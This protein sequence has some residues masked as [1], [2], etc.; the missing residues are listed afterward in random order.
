MAIPIEG[1]C[2]VAQKERIEH[3]LIDGSINVPNATELADD[4]IWRCAF[5]AKEDADRFVASLESLGLNVSKGPDSDV[6]VVQ[7]FDESIQPYCEWLQTAPWEKAIIGWMV[8]TELR[9]VT[10]RD[11]W[12]PKVG[13]GLQFHDKSTMNNLEFLRLEGNIEVHLNKDTGKEVFLSRTSPPVEALFKTATNTIQQH[14][15]TVGEQPLEGNAAKAV[16]AAVE[17]LDTALAEAP[18]WWQA[19]WF[20]GKGHLSLGDYDKTYQSLRKAFDLEKSVEAIPRELAGVCLELRKFDEAV[21]VAEQAVS[22][23]PDNPELLG[24][25]ALAYLLAKNIQKAH[26]AIEAA[27]KLDPKDSINV[28]LRQAILD[29]ADGTRPQPNSMAELSKKSKPKKR[30]FWKF[31]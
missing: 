22:L 25:L 2:V 4:H 19:L 3:F 5:M 28:F 23:M 1:Y 7:E 26:K 10:A 24:N 30:P 17:M 31:W 21:S 20:H 12:D 6:V 15:K 14:M 18:D 13:S 9:T 16:A 8:G 27:I 11:G 29:V